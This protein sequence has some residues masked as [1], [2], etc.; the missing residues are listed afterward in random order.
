MELKLNT[1][2]EEHR[3]GH[4]PNGTEHVSVT[5]NRDTGEAVCSEADKCEFACKMRVNVAEST[6]GNR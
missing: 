4:A 1:Y 3:C 6:Q 5:V 2:Q